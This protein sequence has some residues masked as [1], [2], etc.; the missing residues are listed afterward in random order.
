MAVYVDELQVWQVWPHAR[1]ACLKRGSAHLTA[2]VPE[3]LHAF[4]AFL[5]LQRRWF[6]AHSLHPHY[7]LSLA[8]HA[9]ALELGALLVSAREQARRRLAARNIHHAPGAR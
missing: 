7:D 9:R 4:A 8:K 2:D 3:E 1:H 5:G 6:Q